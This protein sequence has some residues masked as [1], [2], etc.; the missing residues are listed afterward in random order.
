M[1]LGAQ[2]Q[3]IPVGSASISAKSGSTL[4]L[5]ATPSYSYQRSSLAR[6]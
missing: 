6:Q 2:P 5:G 1:K 3:K 4:V